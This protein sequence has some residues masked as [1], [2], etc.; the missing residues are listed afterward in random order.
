MNVYFP[1]A[2]ITPVLLSNQS[3]I[4][5]SPSSALQRVCW[6]VC[7]PHSEGQGTK[8]SDRPTPQPNPPSPTFSVFLLLVETSPGVSPSHA[9]FGQGRSQ[10]VVENG[11][12]VLPATHSTSPLQNA[13]RALFPL[14]LL[15]RRNT[16]QLTTVKICKQGLS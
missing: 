9:Q 10:Q 1:I 13:E 12:P 2:L 3:V 6:Y 5:P 14:A 16:Y 7:S 4:V 8:P 15:S 11:A